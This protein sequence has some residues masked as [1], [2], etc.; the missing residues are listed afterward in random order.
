MLV[1]I[2]LKH[3]FDISVETTESEMNSH[4]EI[5]MKSVEQLP[6]VLETIFKNKPEYISISKDSPDGLNK[7]YASQ[8]QKAMRKFQARRITID[9][10]YSYFQDLKKTVDSQIKRINKKRETLN[11]LNKKFDKKIELT[12]EEIDQLSEYCLEEYHGPE[13]KESKDASNKKK[14]FHALYHLSKN[15]EITTL[16]QRIYRNGE[17]VQEV[18]KCV[19]TKQL[20]STIK[21]MIKVLL[22]KMLEAPDF[23]LANLGKCYED[24]VDDGNDKLWGYLRT[25]LREL[26]DTP[27][28]PIGCIEMAERICCHLDRIMN[29]L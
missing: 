14:Y 6:Q 29:I 12:D 24:S 20:T 23:V 10:I 26:H 2:K 18:S 8:I 25:I 11:K 27:D 19:E 15:P 16:I 1:E 4:P 28:R 22:S 7:D 9:N 3:M 5:V 17:L 21:K 13:K